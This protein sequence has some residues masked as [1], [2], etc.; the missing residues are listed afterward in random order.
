MVKKLKTYFNWSTGKDA[1]LAYYYLKK[2]ERYQINRLVTAI[3][4]HHNRVSM[5]GLRR[6]LLV[7][8]AQE[9][10][11]PITTIELPEEPSMEVYNNEMER[12][13]TQ[14]QLDGYTH[15]G[16]GDIFLEDLRIYREKQLNPYNI[17]CHF[18]LWQRDTKELIEEFLN[19]GFKTIVICIKSKL[20]DAS[21]VGRIIDNDF[22]N[23]LP[24]NV[25]PCGENGEFHTFCYDGP[26]F[27]NPIKFVVGD[28]VYREYK[29]PKKE[30]NNNSMGFWFCDLKLIDD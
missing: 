27:N 15:C 6:E 5:H 16:F 13:V 20:L 11:L 14:L 12:V 10:G 9:I 26:I 18:P 21:F 17:K 23:D 28:K 29:N 25:D 7:K 30:N 19:L 1:S 22:I 4:T 8:H 24:D 3:N 2:D